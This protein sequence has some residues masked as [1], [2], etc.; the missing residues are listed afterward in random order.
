MD[1]Q[2]IH[3]ENNGR[4]VNDSFFGQGK[5]EHYSLLQKKIII[6]TITN[7]QYKNICRF[8]TF[9]IITLKVRQ[10]PKEEQREYPFPGKM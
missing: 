8:E 7:I 5:I 1:E 9:W 6:H 10:Y 4:K 3:R 2:G